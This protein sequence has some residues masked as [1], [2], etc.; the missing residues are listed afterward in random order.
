MSSVNLA[1][2]NDLRTTLIRRGI[3]PRYAQRVTAEL[4]DHAADIAAQ[5]ERADDRLGD[6]SQLADEI[7][8]TFRQRT[9]AGRHPWLMFVLLPFPLAVL[10]CVGTIMGYFGSVMLVAKL[11]ELP[12]NLPEGRA[13]VLLRLVAVL[14]PTL[15]T[16]GVT[17]CVCRAARRAGLHWTRAA[18]ACLPVLLF[19]AMT[20]SVFRPDPS[21]QSDGLYMIGFFVPYVMGNVFRNLGWQQALQTL[22]PMLVIGW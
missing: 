8:H 12:P 14:L 11:L 9:F 18:L 1:S 15:S 6:L 17:Y 2:L 13:A 4:H 16:A 10:A 21:G 19:A 22:V 20:L 3:P 5:G 7:T